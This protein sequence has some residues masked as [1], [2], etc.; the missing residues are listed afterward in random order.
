V[1]NRFFHKFSILEK[2][3]VKKKGKE[4]RKEKGK[5]KGT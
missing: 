2:G 5:E 4:K 3:K 1:F